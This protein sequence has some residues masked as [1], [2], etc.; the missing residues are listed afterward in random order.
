MSVV[1][2]IVPALVRRAGAEAVLALRQGLHARAAACHL[3]VR[4]L[5]R[6]GPPLVGAVVYEEPATAGGRMRTNR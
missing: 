5:W 6:A 3:R 2:D 4:R 1:V